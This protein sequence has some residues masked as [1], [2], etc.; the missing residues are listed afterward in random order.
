MYHNFVLIETLWNVKIPFK[1][2]SY[3]YFSFV[4]IETLWNV[5]LIGALGG[6]NYRPTY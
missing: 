3:K 6:L 5:K 1:H 2:N 4:L